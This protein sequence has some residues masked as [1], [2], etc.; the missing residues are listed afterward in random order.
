MTTNTQH[1]NR[2]TGRL[3]TV[4]AGAAGA[5]LLWAV[6]DPWAGHD[7]IVRQN[8]TL[9]HV[10]PLAVVLTALLA[11]LAA[12]ALLA[13]LERTVRHPVRTYR[14]ITSIVL[15]LS[16]TGPLFGAVGTATRLALLGMHLT[17]GLALIIGL[18]GPRHCR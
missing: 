9:Q 15:L 4:A 10:G 7:L 12:W 5:L 13:V 1:T 8:G 11:G 17:V 14:I 3:I 6:N 16:L 18:P 2:R